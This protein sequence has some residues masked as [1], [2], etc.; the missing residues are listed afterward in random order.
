MP[1]SPKSLHE[2]QGLHLCTTVSA[3]EGK[4]GEEDSHR[5]GL[6]PLPPHQSIEDREGL[7][8]RLYGRI[9]GAV[10]GGTLGLG[11]FI[12][13]PDVCSEELLS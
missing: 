3:L 12:L 10:V 11:E 8:E 5:E 9:D 2:A 1:P 13:V 6:F 7:L 4:T